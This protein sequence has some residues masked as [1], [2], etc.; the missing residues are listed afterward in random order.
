MY[1]NVY[2]YISSFES[3]VIAR[4]MMYDRTSEKTEKYR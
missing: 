2:I 3:E 4:F 1:V